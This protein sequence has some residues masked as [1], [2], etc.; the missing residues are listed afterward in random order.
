M[1]QFY[2]LLLFFIFSATFGQAQ[3]QLTNYYPNAANYHDTLY[4]VGRGFGNDANQISVHIGAGKAKIASISDQ[5]LKVI[6]PN[7]ATFGRVVVND[8]IKK[9]NLSF[10]VPFS[11]TYQ[12]SS[13]D[14]SNLSLNNK[15]IN[16]EA[17]LYDLCSCDFDLD[18]DIDI[19][20]VNND[21]AAKLSSV[22]VF[23][24]TTASPDNVTFAKVPGSYFNI[25]QP[26]RNVNCSDL[27]GDGKPELIVSQGGTVAENIYVFQNLSSISPSILRF[28]SPI[29]L[30]TNFEGLTN[31]TRRVEIHDLDGDHKPEIVVS[32][33]TAKVL[34]VFKN[35][36][37]EG[38]IKFP[39]DKRHFINIPTNTLGLAINDID[40]DNKVDIIASNNLGSDLYIVKNT[41]TPGTFSFS[42]PEVIS[43]SGQLVNLVSGDIDGDGKQDIVLTDFDDGAIILLLNQ[44]TSLDIVFASPIRMNA[45]FQPWG[46]TLADIAGNQ[47]T[48]II[49]STQASTDKVLILK[50]NSVPNDPNFELIQA[51]YPAAYRNINV[52]DINNDAKPDILVTEKDAFGN[53]YVD[54]IKN[55]SCT[56]A[57]VFPK[58]PPAI[59]EASPLTL[60]TYQNPSLSYQW[61]KDG[62]PITGEINA[63]LIVSQAGT[64]TLEISDIYSS[65][66]TSSDDIVITEDSGEIPDV[67]EITAPAQVCEGD[68]ISLSVPNDPALTYQ[69]SGPN[70]FSSTEINPV[71]QNAGK[72][73]AGEYLL[74]VRKGLC[75][76]NVKSVFI[77]VTQQQEIS[78]S[79]N[80]PLHLCPQDTVT[81]T[82]EDTGLSNF[83]WFKDD[84]AINGATN[85]FIRINESG[86]FY[87]KATNASGCSTTSS[88]LEIEKNILVANFNMSATAI[89]VGDTIDFSN[90]MNSDTDLTY[91]W[92]FGDGIRKSGKA[93]NYVYNTPGTYTITH[94]VIFGD[95]SCSNY[96]SKILTVHPSPT[97]EIN[98]SAEIICE[99]DTIT[100]SIEGVSNAL[101][102]ENGSTDNPRLITEEGTYSATVS[103]AFGCSITKS[104]TIR[105]GSAP[106]IN[107]DVIGNN[108]IARG[109]SVQLSASGADQYFWTSTAGIE[110]STIANPFVKPAQTTTYL[111]QGVSEDGCSTFSEVT[112]FVDIDQIKLDA[113]DIYSPN[114]DGIED[115]WIISN[116]DQYPD[117][118]FLIFDLQGKEVY[119]SSMPY[120]NDWEGEDFYGS[121]LPEGTY[122]YV[123]RCGGKENKGSGSVTI[124]R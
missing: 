1:A 114:G 91:Q 58:N 90:N 97:F 65:C 98:A 113:L 106:E 36:S 16:E 27:N 31:G 11:P 42:P 121:R 68:N 108:R 35:E 81:L 12:S 82:I 18:G 55:T 47:Q 5:L 44:S 39:S 103:N 51:G 60:Y 28:G 50:N 120:Q 80:G 9:E 79:A 4:I 24:N 57:T 89:C 75:N 19:A 85:R 7:T 84:Q 102:W 122:Y 94:T 117:C 101:E 53:Y 78:V 115:R 3:V 33:Q 23:N 30:N 76:S 118:Y 72:Q 95:G 32:N 63:S 96:E 99:S 109:D 70:G 107:I 105:R 88:T 13:F 34:L 104:I 69:W 6:I 83:Q 61:Y 48:D 100:L 67:P 20:T 92:E 86:N 112:I 52:A 59:C 56:E 10:S 17:G 62:S 14:N 22:N 8:L 124:L 37:S 64:Y 110:D 46:I 111:L 40:G 87:V 38:V 45:A 74:E 49:V 29:V 77:N 116:F 41:S 54:Y 2:S 26:A 25:N 71:I 73:Q 66:V 15:I 43:I 123:V 119:R 21:E 93:L